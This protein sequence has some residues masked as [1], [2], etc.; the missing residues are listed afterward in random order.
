MRNVINL[1]LPLVPDGIPDDLVPAFTSI[2]NALRALQQAMGDL[3]GANFGD[4][5]YLIENTLGT[6]QT[7]QIAN[8][9]MLRV[10]CNGAIGLARLV[11][12]FDSGGGVIQC[13]LSD[14]SAGVARRVH[15]ITI[16][17]TTAAGQ[18]SL[19]ACFEAYSASF[20]GLTPGATY[21]LS[22]TTPGGISTIRTVAAGTLEQEVGFAL[23]GTELIFH[24]ATPIQH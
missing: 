10:A 2:Y 8:M 11:Q 20:A 13:R 6:G 23:S 18:V 21:Y 9:K 24:A 14:A 19:V 4:P 12:L 22:T 7:Y 5:N 16:N 15:G 1:Q 3:T 17:A